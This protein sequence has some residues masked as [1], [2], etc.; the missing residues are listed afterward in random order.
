MSPRDFRIAIIPT[1]SLRRGKANMNRWLLLNALALA[2]L[3]GFANHFAAADDCLEKGDAV[4]AFYVTKIAGA[5]NDGVK[6][7][8]ELCYRCRYGS[9]PMVMVFARETTPEL[10]KLV[11]EIDSAIAEDNESQLRGLV[12]FMGEDVAEVK[13]DASVF[14]E[15]SGV[16]HLPVAIAKDTQT[17]PPNYK[18]DNSAIT[19]FIAEDSQ[20]VSMHRSKTERI[21]ASSLMGR[22]RQLI[23]TKRLLKRE[24]RSTP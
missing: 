6:C 18:L 10:V 7:G 13:D 23:R 8:Q 5:V 21:N 17:G 22:V 20:L 3:A 16:K 24:S 1:F 12:T 15:E 14:A 11:K 19:V 9:R 4:G 2:L